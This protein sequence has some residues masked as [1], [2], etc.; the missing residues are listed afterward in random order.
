MKIAIYTIAKNEESHVH[1]WSAST[2][3]ADYRLVCDTGS[4]DNTKLELEACGVNVVP[5]SVLP[6]RFD[7]A[8]NTGLNLLPPDIDVCIWQDLDEVLLPGWRSELEQAWTANTTS[9]NHRYRH[10][11]NEW[12]WHSKI[13]ARHGCRWTGAVHETLSWLIPEHTIWIPNI[14]L[15]EIQ[16][17]TKD[18]TSYAKLLIKKIAEGD[19]SWKTYYFLANDLYTVD[20]NKS[21]EYRKK[22][23]ELCNDGDMARG[24][25][26]RN[27]ARQYEYLGNAKEGERWLNTSISLSDERE[28]WCYAAEYYATQSNWEMCFVSATRCLNNNTRRDGFTF[29]ASAWG[30]R[31]QELLDI[32][33]QQLGL[34][35]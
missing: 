15:D 33:K 8:R 22:S 26:A 11:G 13:H 14:F 31:P 12:Q 34:C 21:I 32:A 2:E 1:R 16:D 9:A 17:T 24:Y 28:T 23:F 29:E 18:R 19:T 35:K 20:L 30:S 7:T 25:V 4:T 5:I 27:I 10:N 3:D 6:W